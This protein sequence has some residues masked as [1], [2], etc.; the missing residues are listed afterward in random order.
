MQRGNTFGEG[1][2]VQ[3]G[4]TRVGG[5]ILGQVDP[6][7]AAA[8]F[9]REG[10]GD[11]RAQAVDT[12]D[13]DVK[14]GRFVPVE[15]LADG[16]LGPEVE[17]VERGDVFLAGEEGGLND[18]GETTQRDGCG[19]A[20]DGGWKPFRGGG[21]G[22]LALGVKLRGKK[23]EVFRFYLKTVTALEDAAFAEDKDLFTGAEC[24]GDDLPF[25]E[26]GGHAR[27][28]SLE[29]RAERLELES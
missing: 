19:C 16:G 6:G 23:P 13:E 26:G 24:F 25:F 9:G 4:D 12:H 10:E 2:I 21:L 27:R 11:G 7:F 14:A 18:V 3:H 17:R 20:G 8:H 28:N 1:D 22:F 5:E 29:L 15:F